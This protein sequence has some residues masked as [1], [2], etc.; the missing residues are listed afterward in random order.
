MPFEWSRTLIAT[1]LDRTDVDKKLERRSRVGSGQVNYWRIDVAF[2]PDGFSPWDTLWYDGDEGDLD[3]LCSQMKLGA[4]W[5]PPRVR[6]ERRLK[7]PDVYGLHLFLAVNDKVRRLVSDIGVEELE[8]LP[9]TVTRA[10]RLY[11]LH[12]T[13]RFNLDYDASCP[14]NAPHDNIS[15]V[16]R[17]VFPQELARSNLSVF[18]AFQAPGSAARD[19]GF[20]LDPVFVSESIKYRLELAGVAGIAFYPVSISS[21]ERGVRRT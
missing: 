7:R 10:R 4:I 19:A 11:V 17:W 6:I 3:P 9:L 12:S 18:Q 8:L 13:A 5:S 15:A 1:F 16:T 21:R 20:P 14:G 2:D